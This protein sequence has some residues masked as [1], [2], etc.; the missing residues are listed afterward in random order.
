MKEC[1]LYTMVDI[2]NQ[3]SMSLCVVRN[4]SLNFLYC[5]IIT[6]TCNKRE[7]RNIESPVYENK[8][9]GG[10]KTHLKT[11]SCE[12]T[13]DEHVYW[14]YPFSKQHTATINEGKSQIFSIIHQ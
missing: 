1:W 12:I 5:N 3:N 2:K 10:N 6:C 9:S 4:K 11:A 7:K 14:P 13:Y 8:N